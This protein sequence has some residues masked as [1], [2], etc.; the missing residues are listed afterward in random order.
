MDNPITFTI[1]GQ[2][3]TKSK[4]DVEKALKELLPKKVKKVNT[5]YIV[6][7][8]KRYSIKQ[9]L[10]VTLKIG[11]STFITTDAHRVLEKMGFDVIC[12]LYSDK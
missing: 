9:A 4:K 8:G 12:T 1:N 11:Y 2:E 10:S 3:Y 7:Q 5:Y 6:V